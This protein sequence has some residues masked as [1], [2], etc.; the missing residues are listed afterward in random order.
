MQK[1]WGIESIGLM[2]QETVTT[3]CARSPGGVAE[4]PLL[5]HVRCSRQ[6]RHFGRELGSWK[7][8]TPPRNKAWV[9]LIPLK[10]QTGNPLIPP[11]KTARLGNGRK[12]A[13][14][15][16]SQLWFPSETSKEGAPL[17]NKKTWAPGNPPTIRVFTLIFVATFFS[18]WC[19]QVLQNVICGLSKGDRAK[20]LMSCLSCKPPQVLSTI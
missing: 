4:A 18:V 8:G 3:I 9:S 14:T 13:P 17:E 1:S 6:T 20:S 7:R 15:Q 2:F 5:N 10:S 12:E 11:I 16:L 19:C